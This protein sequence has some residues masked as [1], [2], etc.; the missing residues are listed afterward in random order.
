MKFTGAGYVIW[1]GVK[2]LGERSLFTPKPAV[3]AGL[4]FVLSGL[5]IATFEQSH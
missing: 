1:L 4:V 3:A 5:K 2:T